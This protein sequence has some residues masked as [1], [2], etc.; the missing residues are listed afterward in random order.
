MRLKLVL[1]I[2]LLSVNLNAY[3]QDQARAAYL[4]AVSDAVDGKPDFAFINFSAIVENY[5]D[6]KYYSRALFS[7]GE[8]YF[9]SKDY[10]KAKYFFTKILACH[11]IF[12][13]KIFTLAYLLKISRQSLDSDVSK[14]ISMEIVKLNPI[15][16]VFKESKEY[17][18]RSGMNKKYS[19]VYFIDR[20]EI[21]ADKEEFEK[22]PLQ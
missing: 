12:Q 8:Y 16:L 13:E 22:I 20:I 18:Y 11:P 7:I 21:K 14:K 17:S 15:G 1:L 9:Q 3:C 2:L 4:K 5:P 19:A 6:S 10:V